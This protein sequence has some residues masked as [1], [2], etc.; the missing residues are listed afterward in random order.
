MSIYLSVRVCVFVCPPPHI[1]IPRTAS[2]GVFFD[3][4]LVARS[5]KDAFAFAA[6]T[7]SLKIVGKYVGSLFVTPHT[8]APHT[9]AV[10][11]LGS[12]WY[13][14]K[15]NSLLSS[16][17]LLCTCISIA[18]ESIAFEEEKKIREKDNISRE[19]DARS[20][21]TDLLSRYL[22]PLLFLLLPILLYLFSLSSSIS[23]FFSSLFSS[24]HT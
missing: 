22:Y 2:T 15:P 20:K 10:P 12:W 21:R 11:T 24:L 23:S 4:F 14:A 5:L 17:A 3:N 6:A 19:K 16:V 1:L 18:A 8:I 7:F 13:V 9:V